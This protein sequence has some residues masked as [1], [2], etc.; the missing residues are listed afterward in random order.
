MDILELRIAYPG[1][2]PSSGISA[3]TDVPVRLEKEP[4]E[5]VAG[6]SWPKAEL[7]LP[8]ACH[9]TKFGLWFFLCALRDNQ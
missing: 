8:K 4:I 3:R 5:G 9:L 1:P 7:R 2:V 6:Y